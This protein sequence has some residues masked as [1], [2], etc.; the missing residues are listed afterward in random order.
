MKFPNSI[1]YFNKH[2]LNRI[3]G[4]IARSSWGSFCIVHHV[5]RHSGKPYETTIMAFPMDNG[6][7]VALTYG[8]DVDWFRNVSAAGQCQILWHRNEYEIRKIEPMD[9]ETALPHFPRF[10]Q[11]ILRLVGVQNFVRMIYQSDRSK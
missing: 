6:F 10:E 11:M 1:R 9:V 7:A 8:P 4:K 3:T 2:V 5:G